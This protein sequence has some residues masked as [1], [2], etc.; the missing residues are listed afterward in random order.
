[1]EEWTQLLLD[2][3]KEWA[4]TRLDGPLQEVEDSE[5]SLLFNIWGLREWLPGKEFDGVWGDSIKYK[6]MFLELIKS[7]TNWMKET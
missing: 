1:M 7:Q 2:T 6:R 3:P 5:N 4:R